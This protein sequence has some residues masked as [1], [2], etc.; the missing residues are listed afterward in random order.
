MVKYCQQKTVDLVVKTRHRTESLFHTPTD[1]QLVRQ[2]PCPMLIASHTKWKTQ[3]N[4]LLALDLSTNESKHQQ[5]NAL[6]LSWGK[7]WSSIKHSQLHAVYSIPIAKPLLELE[8]VD[9]NEVELKKSPKA[10]QKMDE[11]LTR[12]EM[13]E[14]ASHITAGPPERNIP[15]LASKL[16][17]DLVIMGSIGRK[18]VSGY[19]LGNTAEKVLHNLRT[20]CL[21]VK[22]AHN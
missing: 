18:G 14:V 22:L 17:G 1:W 15:H 5:L 9:K 10:K 2:L 21:I 11:L 8:V 7:R 19:I 6:V 13:S 20:D 3:A 12:L 16:H 4:I